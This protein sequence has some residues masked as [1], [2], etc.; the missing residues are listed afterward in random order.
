MNRKIIALLALSLAACGPSPKA[1]P[2]LAGAS[3]GG[4]FQLVNQDGRPVRDT[5][6]RGRYRVV[7]FGYTYC[8]DVCPVD[9]ANVGAA[10]RELDKSDPDISAKVV[11]IFITVDPERDTPPVLKQ[12]V[13]NFYPRMLGLTGSAQAIAKAA[14]AYRVYYKKEPPAQPGGGYLVN[15]LRVAYLMDPEGKPMAILPADQSGAA[16]AAEIRRWVS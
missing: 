4:P 8:P 16:V 13:S 5:D 10:M 6:F 12:F 1:E 11:P 7:Y 2:P 14:E 3:I 9:M 15:H